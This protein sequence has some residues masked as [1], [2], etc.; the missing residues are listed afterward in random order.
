MTLALLAVAGCGPAERPYTPGEAAA[1][2]ASTGAGPGTSPGTSPGATATASPPVAS[3]TRATAMPSGAQTVEVSDDWRLRVEWPAD[4]DPA[5]KPM[6]D[7][8]VGTREAIAAGKRTYQAELELDAA[9]KATEWVRG[10]TDEGLTM[11]GVARLY[12]LRVVARM[13]RGAQVDACVDET[14]ARV[15]SARTGKAAD[16]QPDWVRAPYPQ[17]VGVRRGDDGVWR[18]RFYATA[19]GRCPR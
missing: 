17:S 8:W 7:Q 13:G 10:F 2:A 16:R 19:R 6:V 9:V 15:V 1:T 12:N 3:A 14:G 4:P 18:L 11:R 5:L